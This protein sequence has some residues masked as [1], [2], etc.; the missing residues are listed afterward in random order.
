VP[1]I[2]VDSVVEGVAHS[3]TL[4][5]LSAVMGQIDADAEAPAAS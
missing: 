3:R 2:T 5:D 4:I 1:F